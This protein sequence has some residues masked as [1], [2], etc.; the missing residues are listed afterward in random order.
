MSS[1]NREEGRNHSNIKEGTMIFNK[2]RIPLFRGLTAATFSL[3]M[4]ASIGYG[5]ADTWR[6][7]VD[8]ALGTS[9]YEID[10]SNQ[11]YVSDYDNA[12]D[13]MN[14]LKDISVTE[15]EEGTALLKNENSAL[16]LQSGA[17]IN[18]WG[19]ASYMPY[20]GMN[21]AGNTDAVDLVDA[22]ENAGFKLDETLQSIYKNIN[23]L[24]TISTTNQWTGVTTYSPVYPNWE[25][26]AYDNFAINEVNPDQF[27]DPNYG[28]ADASWEGQL[29]GSINI[30]TF[31]RPGG[32]G[33]TYK[34]GATE[35]DDGN[36]LDQNPLALSP[37]ELAVVAAAKATGGKVIV[38]LNT[39]CQMEIDPLVDEE[40]EYAV[41]GIVYIGLPNDYQFT[42]IVNVLSGAVNATGAL[43]DTYAVSSTSSPSMMNFGGS[44]YSDYEIAATSA[45][46][47]PR[48]PEGVTN[49]MS[50]SSMANG[51]V[52]YNGSG[53]YVEAEGIYTGY[54]YYETRYYDSVMN[55]AYKA[56]STAGSTTGT[57]WNYD[58]EV[59]YTF[60]YGLSYLDYDEE[61][62]SVSVDKSVSGDITAQIAITNNSDTAGLFRAELYV[63][64][65]YTEYDRLNLVEKAAIQFLNSGKVEVAAHSTEIVTITVPTK[66][67][68]SY[69]AN[70]AGTYILDEGTYY[71]ACGNGAHEAV[72]NVIKAQNS[73]FSE[74]DASK[75]TTWELDE[76]DSE[77]FSYS[78]N[79][80][81]IENQLDKCDVNYY[82]NDEDEIT[83]LSRQDW[84]GTYPIDFNE[85]P[86]TIADSDKKDEWIAEM[87]NQQYMVADDD[88]VDNLEGIDNGITWTDITSND[89]AMNDIEDPMWDSYVE[90][91]PAEEAVGAVAHGGSQAATLSNIDNPIVNQYDGPAG[92]NSVTLSTNNG[93]EGTDPYYVDPNTE[94]GQF[95][96]NIHSQ[97]LAGSSFNPDLAYRW[98]RALGNFGLWASVYNVWAAGLNVHRNPYNGRN[99]EYLSE[100]EMLTNIWGRE[101]IKGTREMGILVGPKHLGFNDQEYNRAGVS[102]YMTEQK[103]RETDLRAFQGAIEDGEALGYMC[104]FNR[105]GATNVAHYEELNKNLIRG[106]WGFKGLITTDYMSNCYY[107]NPESC[108]NASVTMMAD[109]AGNNS[110]LNLGDGGNDATWSYLSEEAISNDNYLV[111]QARQCMKYQLYAFSQTAIANIV[112]YDVTPWWEAALITV[113]IV[114]FVLTA[115]GAVCLILSSLNND[116]KEQN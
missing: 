73:N 103:A 96:D 60:G 4:I 40:S 38:L 89:D 13:M 91:I 41:D 94:E 85:D 28:G 106:E 10:S 29:T 70:G 63:S 39:S 99:I 105:M 32:E 34:P 19:G 79:G 48:W 56:D 35:D 15:G 95:M 49:Y 83:Y 16:P 97:T 33:C 84:E 62:R 80:T 98:G 1:S 78:E 75:V 45:G 111:E 65:P 93:E 37:D 81:K 101:F 113:I 59:N 12:T 17:T 18:L 104:A 20:R 46:E 9:S 87:R 69:D 82:L 44:T 5:I 36:I 55:D 116:K 92:F 67:L 2:K 11:K 90:Q 86:F 110:H 64:V 51:A 61:I 57:A 52:T 7:T 72:N 31:C 88:P 108:I 21:Q 23:D 54:N 107:F 22:L 68:A 58:D 74:G 109:F 6:S 76:F 8:S 43:A 50:T 71:F 77:T 25:A 47:D 27:T 66:Y 42:G 53:Y 14:E 115:A 3:A 102:A 24:H 30:V 100:D 112:T 114:G 26:P